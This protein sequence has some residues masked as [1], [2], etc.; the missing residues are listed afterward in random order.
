MATTETAWY[1]LIGQQSAASVNLLVKCD[2]FANAAAVNEFADV[3]IRCEVPMT[4]LAYRIHNRDG[5]TCKEGCHEFSAEGIHAFA[6]KD[7]LPLEEF[8]QY[9]TETADYGLETTVTLITGNEVGGSYAFRCHLHKGATTESLPCGDLKAQLAAIPI[10]NASMTED[11]LRQ[12]C[13]DYI[14]LETEFPFKF[15]EDFDYVIQSQK[16]PRKLLGGKIYGG[17]PYVSRGAGNLYR[18]AEIY[19]PATGVLDDGSDIFDNIRLFGNACSG[20]ASMAWA[21]VVTS[22]YLGYTMFMTEANGFLPVGPYR[23]SKENVTQF[24][25]T[26]DGYNC[27]TIC[28]EN[29]EQIMF[30]SYAMMKP[31]DGLVCNGHVRMNSAV[32]TV[33]RNAD[34]T[35]DPDASFTFVREQVCY[36]FD[37]NHLRIAPDGS[38]YTAQGRVEYRNTFRQLLAAGYIPVTFAEFKDPSLV[39]PVRIRLAVEPELKERV[40]TSNYAISDVFAELDGKRY[41]YRNMEFFRKEVKLGDIFPEEALTKDTK[42]FCQLYNGQLVKVKQ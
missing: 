21:R 4:K 34:G 6:L 31:A 19:D 12:I 2:H 24:I 5:V 7:A 29:G 32:P 26:E 23:Y 42:I 41:V 38:H 22:A 20:A 13:L 37:R 14:R 1:E 8:H 9:E 25:R 11:Q 15:K 33:V 35:I 17:M 18:I 30:E 16:R 3:E 28:Q 40:L 27:K 36:V 39:Q 10:A